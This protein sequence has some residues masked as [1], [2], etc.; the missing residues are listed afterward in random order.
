MR[1]IWEHEMSKALKVELNGA[2]G[3]GT[4]RAVGE[5]SAAA[6]SGAVRDPVQHD[7]ELT[8]RPRRRRF[9]AEYKLRI[10]H[11]AETCSDPGASGALLRREGLYSS[12][13]SAWRRQRDQGALDALGRARGRP[14]PNPL[15]VENAKLSRRLERAEAELAKARKVI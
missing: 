13:L 9:A 3:R 15:E 1:A 4:E 11:E 2:G 7:P 14:K 6:V 5:R 12:H 8:E 10:L